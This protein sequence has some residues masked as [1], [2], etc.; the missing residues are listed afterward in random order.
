MDRFVVRSGV[1]LSGEVRVQGAKNSALKLMA[2]C[3]LT[4]GSTRLS[5][6]PHIVDVEVMSDVL[7][8]IGASVAR[9]D[10]AA[11]GDDCV[12]RT[13]PE[14]VVTVPERCTPIAPYELVE[15]MR[16]SFVVLGPLIARHGVARVSL[17]G[18]DDFGHRPIDMHLRALAALGA[19]FGTEHG[20][21]EGRCGRL[22][23]A[24]VVLEYPS[25][26]ATDNVLM[27]ATLAKG[28]TVIENAACEPEVQDLAALLV[29]M[30]ARISGAGTSRIEVEG[31]DELRPATHVTVADRVEAATFLA[32]VGLAGG[33]VFVAG[34]RHEHM[35]MYL[36][37]LVALGMEFD[38]TAGG[39]MVR[40]HRR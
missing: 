40:A 38:A 39:I 25:H 2:A 15:K 12:T 36:E 11:S 35:D 30:G 23:G 13:G 16:A 29:E 4:E 37:K 5:N 33:E 18:G 32:A 21:V 14:L 24:R 17:P 10:G 7:T 19:E 1:P 6:V 22:T 31:V 26:T 9:R 20:Y 27:A 28:T 3:L 8:A 34:A